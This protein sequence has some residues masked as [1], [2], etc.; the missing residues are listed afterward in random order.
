MEHFHRLDYAEE[1][2]RRI[3]PRILRGFSQNATDGSDWDKVR[4]TATPEAVPTQPFRFYQPWQEELDDRGAIWIRFGK[5]DDIYRFVGGIRRESWLYNLD[6]TRLLLHFESEVF[7]GSNDATRL[8]AGVVGLYLC[9]MDLPACVVAQRLACWELPNGCPDGQSPVSLERM[10]Q[11]RVENRHD[12]AEA[13]TKDDNSLRVAHHIAT[14]ATLSRVWDPR[15]GVT[16][17][18]VPYALRLGDVAFDPDSISATIDLAVRQWNPITT[19]WQS[20]EISQRIHLPV[21][22]DDDSRLTGFL[23]VPSTDGVSAW[24]LVAGQGSDR[25]G[26]SFADRVPPLSTGPLAIS[27]VVLG[28]AS[29]GESW[30]TT[31][32]RTI[33]LGPLGAY[34]RSQ[35]VAVYWQTDSERA[36]VSVRTTIRLLRTDRKGALSVALEVATEGELAKGITEFQRDVGVAQLDGGSYRLEVELTDLGDGA[37]VKRSAALLLR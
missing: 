34:D 15:S 18:V 12:I 4:F 6:G 23:V 9:G 17:A 11:V 31:G 19:A 10:E 35:K 16:L 30:Q 36:R 29:Q 3:L 37:T 13:T 7:D 33:P 5:P 20:T 8:V 25:L 24:S 32:G 2:F 1:H 22:R 27:D 14:V 21:S 28:A 26:R